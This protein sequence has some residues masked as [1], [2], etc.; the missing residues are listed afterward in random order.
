MAQDTQET[1][2]SAATGSPG[3]SYVQSLIE[4]GGLGLDSP[5]EAPSSGGADQQAQETTPAASKDVSVPGATPTLEDLIQQ[6]AKETHSD[7]NDGHLRSLLER[8]AHKELYIQELKAKQANAAAIAAPT[9]GPALMTAFEKELANEKPP[10]EAGGPTPPAQAAAS[11]AQP[12]QAATPPPPTKY[13]DVGDDWKTPEESLTALNEAWAEN[14][15]T[16]VH[17]I[18]RARFRR[19]FDTDIAPPLINYLT[20]MVEQKLEDYYQ[21]QL[22][23]VV[24]EVRRSVADRRIAE[25]AEFAL[26]ELRKAGA[27]DLDTLF[28]EE[29]GP[30]IEVDGEKFANTPLNRILAR[31]PEI[32]RIQEHHP[33]P[34]KAERMTLISRYK[35]AYQIHKQGGVPAETARKLVE[36]GREGR[37]RDSQDRARQAINAG[38]GVSGHGEKTN[39]G[40]YIQYINNLSGEIPFSSL[41]S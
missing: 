25:S 35:L 39:S 6:Y 27:E 1:A 24:P 37:E 12:G 8:M 11:Q 15:M 23:D 9:T 31:H 5:A 33:D 22:G 38:P 14:D 28:V 20:K 10:A 7:I 17:E 40:S 16:Q 26:G 36:A 21:R 34:K 32:L 4:T 29:E 3:G 41:R 19:N 13:G 18:E 2:T 30:P